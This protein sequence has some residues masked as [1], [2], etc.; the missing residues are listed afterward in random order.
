MLVCSTEK[1]G[2]H[3]DEAN[4]VPHLLVLVLLYSLQC[5]VS[6]SLRYGDEWQGSYNQ[7]ETTKIATKFQQHLDINKCNKGAKIL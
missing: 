7:P 3:G 6:L 1:L 4:N 2:G 5:R